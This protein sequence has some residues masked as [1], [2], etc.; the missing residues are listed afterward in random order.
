MGSSALV[1]EHEAALRNVHAQ[2][3]AFVWPYLSREGREYLV[4]RCAL[5]C[6]DTAAFIDDCARRGEHPAKPYAALV[7]LDWVALPAGL[8]A[9]MHRHIGEGVPCK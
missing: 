1:E 8:R 5:A 3:L 2:P 4:F 9:E 7:A 6:P